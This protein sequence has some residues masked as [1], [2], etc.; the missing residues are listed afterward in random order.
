[1]SESTRYSQPPYSR[2]PISR[3][4]KWRADF[5]VDEKQDH[6]IAR[7]DFTKFLILISGG[8]TFGQFWI[9]LSTLFRGAKATPE[10]VRIAG[11]NDLP[12]GGSLVFHYPTE[13]DSC[14][15]VRL[16]A[17]EFVA[18]S[19]RCTH[20]MCPVVPRVDKGSF[21]CPCHNGWFDIRSGRRTAGPPERPLPR[22]RLET[23]GQDLF[24]VGIEKGTA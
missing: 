9:A 20:L 22:V 18:F 12:V 21:H 5:P 16:A 13:K 3:R 19:N 6:F 14:V 1:M 15:L 7:R 2:Q 23:K 24:A 17:D 4:E 8:F 11:K 10:G